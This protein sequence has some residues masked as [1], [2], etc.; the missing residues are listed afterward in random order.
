MLDYKARGK[1]P[2]KSILHAHVHLSPTHC[3]SK[4][5]THNTSMNYRWVHIYSWY[6][7]V[8]WAV[9]N[10]TTIDGGLTNNK[11]LFRTVLEYPRSRHWR[12]WCLVG[13]HFP[14]LSGLYPQVPEGQV[15]SR[16][17]GSFIRTILTVV[18]ALPS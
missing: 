18:R 15:R 17:R 9:Y 12:I 1:S 8:H 3:R 10:N 11:H 16:G 6:I 14:V 7:L 4:N 13:T 5:Q 2:P